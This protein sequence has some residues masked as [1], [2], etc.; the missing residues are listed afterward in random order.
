MRRI[1]AE[2]EIHLDIKIISSTNTAPAKAMEI[3]ELRKDL[4]YRLG[5]VF[6]SIP[7]L[8]ERPEDIDALVDHFIQKYNTLLHKTVHT[9]SENVKY[10]FRLYH[11]PGNVRELEN[12]IEG[13]MNM[14]GTHEILQFSHLTSDFTIEKSHLKTQA[15]P[16]LSPHPPSHN[17]TSLDEFNESAAPSSDN[18]SC[19]NEISSADGNGLKDPISHFVDSPNH[20]EKSLDIQKSHLPNEE[21]KHNKKR[22]LKMASSAADD[23]ISKDKKNIEEALRL[24]NGNVSQTAIMLNISRQSLHKKINRLQIDRKQILAGMEIK[25][26]E[27]S[28]RKENGNITHAAKNIG[29]SRQL[30][31]YKIKKYRIASK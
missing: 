9:L 14:V 30:L 5:V 20:P 3:G 24:C 7:S 15:V 6:L 8:R 19:L 11:W 1:G 29:I 4:F 23:A 22:I 31:N 25:K 27:E 26:I 21:S 12:A 2:D 28:L 13:A 16:D 18:Q 10:H 17:A